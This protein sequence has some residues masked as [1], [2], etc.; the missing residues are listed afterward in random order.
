VS[1]VEFLCFC[2][3]VLSVLLGRGLEKESGASCVENKKHML[4]TFLNE[5]YELS[6][7]V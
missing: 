7:K 5:N 6:L 4:T 3:S 1:D 2:P